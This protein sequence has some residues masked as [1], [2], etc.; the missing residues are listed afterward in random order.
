MEGG[1][2]GPVS[3]EHGRQVPGVPAARDDEAANDVVHEA[4]TA[5]TAAG[6]RWPSP[7][8]TSTGLC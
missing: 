4:M 8:R 7:A 3:A 1:I 6:V 5:S 2:H